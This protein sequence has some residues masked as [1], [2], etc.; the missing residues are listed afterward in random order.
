[1]TCESKLDQFDV[2]EGVV[3]SSGDILVLSVRDVKMG[4][5]IVPY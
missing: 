3:C 5:V 4:L 2:A 1:M